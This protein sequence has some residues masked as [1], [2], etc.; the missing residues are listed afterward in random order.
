M[1]S[2]NDDYFLKMKG[3]LD[4]QCVYMVEKMNEIKNVLDSI[5]NFFIFR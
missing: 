2:Q 3:R 1:A 5:G 4:S